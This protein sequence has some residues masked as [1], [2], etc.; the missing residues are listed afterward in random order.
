M[1]PADDNALLDR[2]RSG[3]AAA[4]H[5]LV[6]RYHVRMVRLARMFVSTDASAEEVVQDTWVV[7]LDGLDAFE[8]RSSLLTW[9]SRI[10][11]NR[12]KTRGG[13]EA[14]TLPFSAFGKAQAEPDEAAVD[15]TRFGANGEWCAPPIRWDD[16]TPERL[17]GNRQAMALAAEEIQQLP[18]RQRIIIILRDAMGWTADEVCNVLELAETNQRVLLHRARSRIRARLE[19][20]FKKL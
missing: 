20:H 12:A 9:I 16:E 3:D 1:G 5:T 15:P 7:V 11:V 13:R 19:T 8:G 6:E 17:I 18:E 4:F 14:R 2:L 10:V